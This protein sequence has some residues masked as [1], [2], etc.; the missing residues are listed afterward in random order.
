MSVP[1]RIRA[2]LD[3][4]ESDVDAAD[5]LAASGNRYGAYHCQQ[6]VEKLVKAVLLE[7]G[8]EAGLEHR[9]DVLIHKLRDDD[10]WKS[11]LRPWDRL[12]PYA[13]TFRYPTPGGRI[14][15]APDPGVVATDARAIRALITKARAELMGAPDS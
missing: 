12:T 10:G 7:R 13:T 5:A 11:V 3:L 1:R 2:L 8:I 14:P 6:A 9:L 4:A 15:A